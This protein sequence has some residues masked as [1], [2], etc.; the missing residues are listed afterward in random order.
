MKDNFDFSVLLFN[1]FYVGLI[2]TFLLKSTSLKPQNLFKEILTWIFP[3]YFVYP[4]STGGGGGILFYLCP[5]FHPSV[6]PSVQDIFRN[7]LSNYWW[8]KSDIWSQASYRY[9]ILWEVFLDPSDPL[10]N[11]AI[12]G[13]SCFWLADLF[14]SSPPK[15]LCQ[16]CRNLVGSIYGRSSI[17]IALFIPIR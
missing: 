15:T 1:F 14:K 4:H 17:K 11:M 12:T 13:N 3:V 5:S 16:M 10:T 7:F 6:L 8:Q 2:A 9:A